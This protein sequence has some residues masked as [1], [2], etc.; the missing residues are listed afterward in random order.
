EKP[1]IADIKPSTSNN[2]GYC[3]ACA[4]ANSRHLPTPK[5]TRRLETAPLELIYID[6]SGEADPAARSAHYI[7]MFIYGFTTYR[8]AYMIELKSDAIKALA[9]FV[10][11]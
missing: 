4:V 7:C 10:N 11:E 2:L 3:S 1:A 6:L 5:M 8:W 9:L